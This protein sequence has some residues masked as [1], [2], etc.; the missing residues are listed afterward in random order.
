M[1]RGRSI[2]ASVKEG[3]ARVKG[4]P[5]RAVDML[6]YLIQLARELDAALA[7]GTRLGPLHGVP[8]TIK[9]SLDT[10]GMITPGG[11]SW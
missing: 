11:T 4:Q 6:T 8:M 2:A 5:R 7:K 3:R 1:A 10:A 9:N